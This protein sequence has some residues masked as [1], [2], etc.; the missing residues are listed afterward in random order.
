M[1]GRKLLAWSTLSWV[2]RPQTFVHRRY[3]T[4][5]ESL[6]L[7]REVCDAARNLWDS[8]NAV[9]RGAIGPVL[10][11][12]D[13]VVGAETGSGKTLAYLLPVMQLLMDVPP[14]TTTAYPDALILVPNRELATQAQRV[15]GQLGFDVAPPYT[16]QWTLGARH[17]AA[18]VWPYRRGQCPRVVVATPSFADAFHKDLDLWD[19]LRMLILDEADAL[20]DGSSK[21]QLDRIL[22]AL[23]RVHRQRLRLQDLDDALNTTRTCQRIVVAATLPSYGLKSV[24]ALVDKHFSTASRI[25]GDDG[26]PLPIHAPVPSLRQTFIP[27][28][29]GDT[30]DLVDVIDP[31]E[32]TMVFANTANAVQRIADVLAGHNFA[33]APYHKNVAPEDRLR[34]LDAFA[35]GDL[36]VLCCTDLAARGLD[37][38]SVDHVVQYEFALNVVNHLHRVGRAARAGAS[39]RATNFYGPSSTDLV[40]ALNASLAKTNTVSSAFSRRRGF[41]QKIKKQRKAAQA[42]SSSSSSDEEHLVA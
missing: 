24:E 14:T 2:R 6:G 1:R 16:S 28:E 17:G 22:V 27:I 23:K 26:R 39:G 21:E 18:G 5:W 34:T 35:R 12:K 36:R 9:Q 30:P 41:R 7:R 25:V 42:S 10:Q 40:N 15:A 38:P 19:S 3:A 11:G 20:L 31:T 8:P 29:D 13:C 32:R 37:L 4:T 33:C